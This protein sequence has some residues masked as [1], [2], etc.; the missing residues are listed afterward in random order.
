MGWGGAGH[1][2]GLRASASSFP[3]QPVA[4]ILAC[5]DGRRSP[6][7]CSC[8]FCERQRPRA[9]SGAGRKGPDPS[10]EEVAVQLQAENRVP[11]I[12]EAFER[13]SLREA[14]RAAWERAFQP[15]RQR[16]PER[17]AKTAKPQ[18]EA[19]RGHP[20]SS[21]KARRPHAQE[22]PREEARPSTTPPEDPRRKHRQ[23]REGLV[24]GKRPSFVSRLRG[25]C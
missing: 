13:R 18:G 7:T 24:A 2:Q 12:V 3:L 16:E 5:D 4:R 1:H 17:R 6:A 22:A 9:T 14:K 20:Q 25:L 21:G 10:A 23:R 8:L 11:R 19:R 15:T